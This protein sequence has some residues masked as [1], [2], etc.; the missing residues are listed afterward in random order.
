M[1]IRDRDAE[2]AHGDRSRLAELLGRREDRQALNEKLLEPGQSWMLWANAISGLLPP[3]EVCDFGCG[4]G[5]LTV[6]LAR[7]ARKVVAID[8]N[9]DALEKAKARAGRE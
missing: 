7:W 6:E 9:P 2:D 1:C 8:R 4:T 5:V 3:L